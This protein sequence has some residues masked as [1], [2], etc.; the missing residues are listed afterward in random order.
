[1]PVFTCGASSATLAPV[2]GS[3]A[4]YR[5]THSYRVCFT[6][7]DREPRGAHTRVSVP[8][9]PKLEGAGLVHEEDADTHAAAARGLAQGL[10]KRGALSSLNF[11]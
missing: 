6:A 7:V 9:W 5:Y 4:A 1:M 2:A 10:H 8:C 11:F 3:T